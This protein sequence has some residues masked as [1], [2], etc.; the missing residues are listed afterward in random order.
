[1]NV[2][3]QQACAMCEAYQDEG[4]ADQCPKCR[5]SEE[6][7]DMVYQWGRVGLVTDYTCNAFKDKV[8]ELLKIK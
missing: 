2:T 7:F 5:I 1:M 4:V 6:L 8:S 3:I